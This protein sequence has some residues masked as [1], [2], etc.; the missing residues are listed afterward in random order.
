MKDKKNPDLLSIS[1][2]SRIAEVSRKAL[3]FYDNTGVFSPRYTAPNGYRYY[4]HEQI[5]VI[6]VVNMLKELGMPLSRIKGYTSDI[7]PEKAITLLK[8]QGA[9]LDR[10]ISEFQSVRDM[11]EVKLRKLE[12][13]YAAESEDVCAVRILHFDKTPVFI[14][15]SFQADREHIPDDMWLDFYM[16]CKQKHISFGYP[17][18]FLVPQ[19]NLMKQHTGEVANIIAYV[20]HTGYANSFVPAGDYVTACGNGGLQ[21]TEE[22]YTRIFEFIKRNSCQITGDAYE[23]RLIDEV[24]SSAKKDQ[25]TRVRIRIQHKHEY[26]LPAFS[27]P[28][29]V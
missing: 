10:K 6:S 14:S 12:E 19:K 18:G 4:A 25:V 2:F 16:K 17:E 11:L 8:E 29:K 15:D 3:I 1:E 21:D 26:F 22:I 27:P 20:G 13:G 9:N 23:E 24:G 28:G 5:Y 7:T